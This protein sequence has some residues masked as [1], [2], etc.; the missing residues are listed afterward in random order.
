MQCIRRHGPFYLYT[1]YPFE[2]FNRVVLSAIHG[3]NKCEIQAAKSIGSIQQINCHMRNVTCEKTQEAFKRMTGDNYLSEKDKIAMD[4]NGN[5]AFGRQLGTT[6]KTFYKAMRING[7]L[8][9]SQE[10]VR[11]RTYN[12]SVVRLTDGRYAII[13][14]LFNEESKGWRMFA[15][16]I[17]DG[18]LGDIVSL[19]IESISDLCI[20]L[21]VDDNHC[22]MPLLQPL[23]IFLR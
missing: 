22:P 18:K 23:R 8:F 14:K 11:Q 4:S 20:C 7:V 19:P 13:N 3:T 12:N 21:K 5:Y 9:E 6:G 16:E 15:T 17:E 10:L 2:S 1:C